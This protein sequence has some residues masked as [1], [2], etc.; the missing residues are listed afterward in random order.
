MTI[1]T[2]EQKKDLENM[3][4]I[5]DEIIKAMK[6]LVEMFE[7]LHSRLSPENQEALVMF[8]HSHAMIQ[9]MVATMIITGINL[10]ADVFC[11]V[12]KVYEKSSG[13]KN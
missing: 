3:T 6:C 2:E 13:V 5:R 1:L 4:M 11:D 9:E 7:L 12:L 8:N 10:P